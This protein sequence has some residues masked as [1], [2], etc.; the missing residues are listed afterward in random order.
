M[1]VTGFANAWYLWRDARQ[2]GD[3]F[4][5]TGMMHALVAMSPAMLCGAGLSTF[6]IWW[7]R[8]YWLPPMWMLCYALA[9]L[10]TRSF[11][12]RSIK[13]LGWTFFAAGFIAL[14]ALS[15]ISIQ[16]SLSHGESHLPTAANLCMVT[17]FG[18][19]H[20]IYAAF[21]W[22]HGAGKAGAI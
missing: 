20:L 19:F 21:T 15:V 4:L 7:G 16:S 6:F 10:A 2:R 13:W 8:P 11:A 14:L 12:P 17:A 1:V 18:L 3:H 5:S 22:P 9:L